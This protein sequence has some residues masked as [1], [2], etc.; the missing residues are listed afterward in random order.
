MERK[1]HGSVVAFRGGG[2][3]GISNYLASS[4]R[5]TNAPT[6]EV[7]CLG[8]RVASVLLPGDANC[9]GTVD[10]ADLNIV[11]S[12]FDKT[13]QTWSEGDF[14]GNGTVNG[15]DLNVVLSELRPEYWVV[16]G[17]RCRSRAGQRGGLACLSRRAGDLEAEWNSISSAPTLP[18]RPASWPV[19]R[20]LEMPWRAGR[21]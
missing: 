5:A 6:Y 16:I 1:S 10:G 20:R 15:A 21:S 19:P 4:I 8:F 3:N 11:L 9:D 12:N 17:R 18:C 13:G 7:D 2:W 14:D